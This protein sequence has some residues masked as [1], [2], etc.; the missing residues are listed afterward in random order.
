MSH[1][2][3]ETMA[4]IWQ[5]TFQFIFLYENFHVFI[6]D[7]LKSIAKGPINNKPAKVPIMAW[8]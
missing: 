1:I 3:T 5:T 8:C 4:T 6:H 2:E 7:W